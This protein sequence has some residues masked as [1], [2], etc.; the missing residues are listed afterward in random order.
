ML[1]NIP[2][3]RLIEILNT[4]KYEPRASEMD[5]ELESRAPNEASYYFSD[6][7]GEP[8]FIPIELECDHDG[9]PIFEEM[10]GYDEKGDEVYAYNC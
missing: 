3:W 2:T 8:I 1:S 10:I 4:P 9:N 5:E 6:C 7:A